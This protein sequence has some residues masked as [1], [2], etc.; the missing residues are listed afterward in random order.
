MVPLRGGARRVADCGCRAGVVAM[1][2]IALADPPELPAGS[3]DVF[4]PII[5]G[6]PPVV[7]VNPVTAFYRLLTADQRQQRGRLEVCAC[8]EQAAT[9]K[10]TDVVLHEYWS[11]RAF[12]GE[13]PNYTARRFGCNLPPEYGDNR[14]YCESMAAGSPDAATMFSSLANSPAHKAH[15]FGENDFFREQTRVGVGVAVGGSWG[16]VWV[17]YIATCK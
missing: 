14:N 5:G 17:I 7:A 10:A 9:W 15:L 13:M 12:N 2:T 8:L 6:P 3:R 4:L 16:W 1:I 11:H